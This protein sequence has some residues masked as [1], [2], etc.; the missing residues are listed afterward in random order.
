MIKLSKYNRASA[1]PRLILVLLCFPVL[2][3][4]ACADPGMG[5]SVISD[6]EIQI[7]ASPDHIDVNAIT[8]DRSALKVIRLKKSIISKDSVDQM[9][10]LRTCIEH[11]RSID[12]LSGPGILYQENRHQ[13]LL[14]LDRPPPSS[15]F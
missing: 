15:R 10:K 12:A 7:A 14:D 5:V 4:G 6:S 11:H 2:L 3:Y 13:A 8:P 1:H 9:A